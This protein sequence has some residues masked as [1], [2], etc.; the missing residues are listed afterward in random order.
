MDL[1]RVPPGWAHQVET[2]Q[3]CIKVAVDLWE[4]RN[5]T[6]YLQAQRLTDEGGLAPYAADDY[7]NLQGVLRLMPWAM[8]KVPV[9]KPARR[10]PAAPAPATQPA[11]A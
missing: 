4:P 9:P 1:V 2:H 7:Q 3:P 11:P 10:H 8:Q 6:A 5:L